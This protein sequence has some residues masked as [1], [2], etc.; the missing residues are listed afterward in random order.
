MIIASR[1]GAIFLSD[2]YFN[3]TGVFERM[4]ERSRRTE[5]ADGFVYLL[6]AV[7]YPIQ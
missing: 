4:N 7:M 2:E 5:G 6:S 3:Q 1:A